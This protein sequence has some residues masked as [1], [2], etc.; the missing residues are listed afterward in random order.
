MA[1]VDYGHFG[2]AFIT[3][4]RY[5]HVWLEHEIQWMLK[6]MGRQDYHTFRAP[7]WDWRR[8]SQLGSGISG[9]KLFIESRLGYTNLTN[10][11]P[12]VFGPYDDWETICWLMLGQICDP[13]QTTGRLQRCPFPDRC[14]SSNPDW[15]T[16]QHVDTA[17]EFENFDSP[18]WIQNIQSVGFR[19]YIDVEFATAGFETCREDR[20][21]VCLSAAAPQGDPS[22][23]I[24]SWGITLSLRLHLTVC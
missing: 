6:K 11:F 22:C 14:T 15:P 8:E 20:M 16:Q 19:N 17:L 21:C 12:V 3:W 2:P 4:H 24:A 23:A 5:I 10:G 9:E 7:Y 18:P 1:P 13:R